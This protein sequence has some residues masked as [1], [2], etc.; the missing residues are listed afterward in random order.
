MLAD[1]DQLT[2][3]D[4][5][6]A[7]YRWFASDVAIAVW[8][9]IR[10]GRDGDDLARLQVRTLVEAYRE[11]HPLEPVWLEALPVHVAYRRA[12]LLMA[13]HDE[14]PARLRDRWR[15]AVL[16]REIHLPWPTSGASR[17]G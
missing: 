6:V 13:L 16:R 5:D 17:T 12:L 9:I 11:H 15:Q 7:T 3:I 4:L 14:L 1:G 8:S 10:E 2:L